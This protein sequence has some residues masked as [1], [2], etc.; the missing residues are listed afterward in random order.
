MRKEVGIGG[1]KMEILLGDYRRIKHTAE[2][3]EDTGRF[4]F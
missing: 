1:M 3:V 4:E 2:F